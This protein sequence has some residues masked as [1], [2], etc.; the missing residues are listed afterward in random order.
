[1]AISSIAGVRGRR[2]N[3]VYGASKAGLTAYYEGLRNRLS[4]L[5]R[6]R[7]PPPGQATDTAMTKGQPGLFWPVS[8][9]AAA[10]QSLAVAARGGSREA[11]VPARWGLVAAVLW[12]MIPSFIF[13]R[14]PIF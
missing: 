2:G 8:A 11:F 13:R 12:T 7:R 5:R 9:E 1:M 10:H 6:Q 14:A 4:R 3:P